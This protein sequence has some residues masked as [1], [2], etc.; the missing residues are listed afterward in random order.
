MQPAQRRALK[1]GA[2]AGI[3]GGAA[4]AANILIDMKLT[5]GV[6]NDFRLLGQIGPL[7]KH[8][9]ITGPIIHMGNAVALG[10]LYGVVEPHL[11]GD[12]GMRG[13]TFAMIENTGLWPLVMLLDRIHPAIKDGELT[14]YSAPFPFAVEVVRHLSY[15]AALGCAYEMLKDRD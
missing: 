8:W 11:K 12:G 6:A 1:N 7:K 5:G 9:R 13:S 3:A 15:G 2:I 10:A 4:M 14:P